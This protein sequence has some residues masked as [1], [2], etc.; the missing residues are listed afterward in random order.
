MKENMERE[1]HGPTVTQYISSRNSNKSFP[2][3]NAKKRTL[4]KK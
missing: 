3:L 4:I 2:D 1:K